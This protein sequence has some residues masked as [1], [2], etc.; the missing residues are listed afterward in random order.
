MS[1]LCTETAVKVC[2]SSRSSSAQNMLVQVFS[3]F[4]SR[5][6]ERSCRVPTAPG[7]TPLVSAVVRRTYAQCTTAHRSGCYWSATRVGGISDRLWP[8]MMF[9][10]LH[11]MYCCSIHWMLY[12]TVHFLDK[13]PTTTLAAHRLLL[14]AAQSATRVDILQKSVTWNPIE[15][16]LCVGWLYGSFF[17]LFTF[18]SSSSLPSFA[19]RLAEYTNHLNLD[20]SLSF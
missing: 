17:G 6:A 15:F 14:V 13:Q 5:E 9:P 7:G 4:G 18:L 16:L 1:V 20:T 19:A 10:P 11:R 8:M 2:N 3:S 12:N